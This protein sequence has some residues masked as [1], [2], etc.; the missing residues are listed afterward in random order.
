MDFFDGSFAPAKRGREHVGS[1][2]K[3][4][5]TKWILVVNDPGL[6]LGFH[7]ES[8]TVAEVKLAAQTLDAISVSR[9]RGRPKRRPEKL[10]ADRGYDSSAFRATLRRRGIRMCIPPKRRPANW[11]AKRGRPVVARRDDYRQR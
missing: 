9:A 4:K 10:V 5:G 7:L 6:P 3:G 8:T 2:L 11:Q 1:T